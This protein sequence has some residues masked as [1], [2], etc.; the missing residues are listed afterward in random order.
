MT[1]DYGR[2]WVKRMKSLRL[3]MA[4]AAATLLAAVVSS[5][6]TMHSWGAR[7]EDKAFHCWDIGFG[8]Y[9]TD[10]DSHASFGDAISA[11]WTWEKLETVRLHYIEAF[12][13]LWAAIA[14]FLF[15]IFNKLR[16]D[17]PKLVPIGMSVFVVAM[18]LWLVLEKRRSSA[19]TLPQSSVPHSH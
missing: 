1:N 15:W 2:P 4:L 5:I 12:W 18:M 19:E 17:K 8:S 13:L 10:M 11:G 16:H 9:W 7:I 6:A 3:I 14:S